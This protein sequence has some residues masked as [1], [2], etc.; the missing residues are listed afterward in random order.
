VLARLARKKENN[1]H[2]R[3]AQCCL[4]SYGCPPDL[5]QDRARWAAACNAT[6]WRAERA[7]RDNGFL[8]ENLKGR[9]M[10][11]A[12]ALMIWSVTH[13]F[14]SF[15]KKKEARVHPNTKSWCDAL[16]NRAW[17]AGW[18]ALLGSCSTR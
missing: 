12:I 3:M 7:G 4:D 6:T 9:E 16:E 10:L 18:L 11:V 1:D 17:L 15:L 14:F 5:R 13:A 8:D 2:F